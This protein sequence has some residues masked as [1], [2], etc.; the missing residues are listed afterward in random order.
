MIARITNGLLTYLHKQTIKH[1][2]DLI[3]LS[4]NTDI[5]S[6]LCQVSAA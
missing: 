5:N 1:T 3:N 4:I 2:A 6:V